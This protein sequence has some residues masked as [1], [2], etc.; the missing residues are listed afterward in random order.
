[1]QGQMQMRGSFAS[2]RMTAKTSRDKG[3][4]NGNGKRRSRSLRD[5]S[6]K[7]NGGGNC[8]SN[9]NGEGNCIG[10]RRGVG[11]TLGGVGSSMVA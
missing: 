3:K 1:M 11:E 4:G 6:Q 8:K 2:L 5:D 9:C 7:N 10:K